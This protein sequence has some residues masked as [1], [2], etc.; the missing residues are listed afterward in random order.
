MPVTM[1]LIAVNMAWRRSE[2]RLKKDK[3][4][5]RMR[6]SWRRLGAPTDEGED[7]GKVA[8]KEETQANHPDVTVTV[9]CCHQGIHETTL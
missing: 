3:V 8:R 4:G 5:P 7:D 2:F 6:M 9:R 1:A